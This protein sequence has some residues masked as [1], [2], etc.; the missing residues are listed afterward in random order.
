MGP[1]IGSEEPDPVEYAL[2]YE[3]H[4]W[5]DVLQWWLTNAVD[6]EHGGVFT[7][8]NT[9]GTVLHSTDKYSWSQGRWIWTMAACAQLLEISP[10][11][12]LDH[13]HLQNLAHTSAEFLWS[14][15]MLG[16]GRVANVLTRQGSP[17]VGFTGPAI[18]ASVFADLFA[19]LGFA[20]LG[21]SKNQRD[22]KVWADRAEDLLIRASERIEAGQALTAP[23][24]V[25]AGYEAFAP[26]MILVNTATEVHRATGS[27]RSRQ[28]LQRSV[29]AIL[30]RF[31]DDADICELTGPSEQAQTSMYAR[32]RNPGHA[33][34]TLWFLRD[35]A[36]AVPEVA[37]LMEESLD[38]PLDGWLVDAA[39]LAIERGWDSEYGG[40]L[41]FVDARGGM[42]TGAHEPSTYWETIG[43][44]WDYKLWWP[45]T[46]ALYTLSLLHERTDDPR[47]SSW[48]RRVH[49]YT[50]SHFPADPGNEWKQILSRQ[51]E[52]LETDAGS[53][54]P[55]KDPFHLM[56]SLVL[57][58][59]MPPLRDGTLA[60]PDRFAR[61]SRRD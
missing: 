61:R 52:Q 23:Y 19:A 13:S 40:I 21:H 58:A 51:G 42:P 39:L 28:I 5:E 30:G 26:H 22:R 35:A 24:P 47:I 38:R 4:L 3:R 37:A 33:L 17:T 18:Y 15:G 32:H 46:E 41:R 36:D 60:D 27:E 48:F 9:D 11:P 54:L 16:E 29:Q 49:D 7:F 57:L 2:F 50:F 14:H 1:T 44:T 20:A 56:R 34:E 43:S 53:A 25:P 8:W 55:V 45:H 12:Q 10:H 6:D 31:I 59:S